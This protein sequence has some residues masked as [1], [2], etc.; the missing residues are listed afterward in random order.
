MK[1]AYLYF[2]LSSFLV[3]GIFAQ[4]AIKINSPGAKNPILPG[5]FADPTIV[6]INDIYYIYATTD[7]EMLGSGAPTLWYSNDFQN[8]YNYTMEVPTLSDVNLRNFWAPDIISGSDGKYYLYFGNCQSGCNIYGYVSDKPYGP[9]AKLNADDTPVIPNG[10]PREG[11]PSLDAQFFKDDDGK[12]YAY[13]GTWVHYNNGYAVGQLNNQTMG[14]MFESKNIPLTETPKPFEA[15]YMMKRN[16]KYILMYSGASCHDE[17]YNVR[18]SYSDNPYGPF[19]PGQN[20]P[21]LSTNADKSVHG[22]GHHSVFQNNDDYYIV[23]HRHDYPFTAGGLARQICIDSLIFE[24]DSTIRK[25]IPSHQ[26]INYFTKSGVPNDI[27]YLAKTEASSFYQL[28]SLDLNYDYLPSY[29]TDNNNATLWKAVSSSFPQNLTIDLGKEKQINRIMTQFEFASYYYQYKIEYSVDGKKWQVYADK[30]QNRTSGSPMIDDKEVRAQYLKLTILDVEKTGLYAAVWN[31][32]VYE[33]LFDI[34]LQLK[35]KPSTEGTGAKSKK[36]MLVHIDLKGVSDTDPLSSIPNKGTIGG[37]FSKSGEVSIGRDPE[38]G[39]RYFNFNN[40]ALTL[41]DRS[42]PKCLEWNGAYTV[43]V[44]VKNPEVNKVDECLVSWCDRNEWSLANSY[45]AL[46]YNSGKFGAAAH[47]EWHFDMPYRTV[48]AENQWHHIVLTFDGVVEKVYVDGELN[49]SQNMTLASAIKNAKIIIG[50]SDV[51]EN[52]TGYLA[53]MR[54]YDYAMD[55]K[56][57]EKIS[58]QTK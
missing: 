2:V 1:K 50:A 55:K 56:E 19:T 45:N 38:N 46:F 20:N 3:S 40:G 8:W 58:K 34:P 48:P 11:F 29:A 32:K 16:G 44:W 54:M 26:G 22:P 43:A 52:Y 36:E 42:V 14:N 27:A 53:S 30:S 39:I 57:V 35:N 17:T 6:K 49:N 23:Y 10:Y 7:N 33:N 24:N 5:W 41:N 25:V 51:G 31:I 37:N 9:W 4:E 15:A 13:W 21:I 12:I 28:K 18:Y 47:L